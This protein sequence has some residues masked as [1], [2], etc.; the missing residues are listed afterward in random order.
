M[1]IYNVTT[2]VSHSIKD[3][4]LAWMKKKHIPEILQTEC[5]TKYQFVRLLETDETEGQ[6]YATQYYVDNEDKYKEYLEKHAPRLRDDAEK[7]W[8]NQLISF[9]SIMEI[10]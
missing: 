6:T 8:G 1:F 3:A 2:H 9:R 5:F 4:W 7:S 10:I